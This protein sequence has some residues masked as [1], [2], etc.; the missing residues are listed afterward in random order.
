MGFLIYLGIGFLITLLL[1]I[2]EDSIIYDDPAAGAIILVWPII[3]AIGLVFVCIELL[4][5]LN[6]LIF[7]GIAYIFRRD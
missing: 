5:S 2:P 4:G 1:R 6:T 3:L 7:K